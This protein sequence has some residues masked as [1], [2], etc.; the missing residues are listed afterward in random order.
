MGIFKIFRQSDEERKRLVLT[1]NISKTV[2]LLSL[3]VM[4]MLLAQSFIQVFDNWFVY[5]F[6]TLNNGAAVAYSNTALN[7]AI[8]GGIGLSVAGTA[9]I[10]RLNGAGDMERVFKYTRQFIFL[11]V[12]A[13]AIVSVFTMV[14]TPFYA[15]LALPEIQDGV[16]MMMLLTPLVVPFQYYNTAYYAIKNASGKAEVQFFFTVFM[17]VLKL[18][19]NALFIAVFKMG[20]MGIVLSNF[21]AQAMIS[22]I[23]SKDI[24]GKKGLNIGFKG[25]RPEKN[26]LKDF[27]KVGIPSVI[28]NV[29]MSIGFLL[30]NLESMKF[31]REV[32]NTMSV[33][34]SITNLAYST[35]N[36]FGTS[37]TSMVS[38]NVGAMNFKRAKE[39]VIYVFKLVTWLSAIITVIMIILAPYTAKM[40]IEPDQIS[41]L[42]KIV[43]TQRIT[44]IGVH[45]FAVA[46][47][48]CG[49]FVALGQTKI[50][51][52][53]GG[54]RVIG[55]RYLFIVVATR[56]FHP[57]Y[58][59]IPLATLFSNSASLLVA[60]ALYRRIDWSNPLAAFSFKKENYEGN[61]RKYS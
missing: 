18:I 51:I 14:F 48:M 44:I 4:F 46:S 17:L 5:N 8:N 21:L 42:D 33:A 41:L 40:F 22:V 60:F 35:L 24:F 3:P 45:G 37:I 12:S 26:I 43:T 36:S 6:S 39:I 27:L 31:G 58:L 2:I 25:F 56:L 47:I 52:V 23:I 20:V 53:I 61:K 55:F 16:R 57:T 10:G 50:P 54:L 15:S 13:S 59:I 34:N 28:T 11:M 1:D 49:V 7:I 30:I 38:M 29:T 19:G 9:L 32:L